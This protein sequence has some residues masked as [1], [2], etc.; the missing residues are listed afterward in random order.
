[1]TDQFGLP[2]PPR[3]EPPVVAWWIKVLRRP[4]CLIGLH[5]REAVDQIVKGKRVL[6]V[7]VEETPAD[8]LAEGVLYSRHWRGG[9][10]VQCPFCGRKW[11][12]DGCEWRKVRGQVAEGQATS[13]GEE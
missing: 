8:K 11:R 9:F 7:L 12:W 3:W 10:D 1:M 2:V 13:G 5:G 4:L 6:A